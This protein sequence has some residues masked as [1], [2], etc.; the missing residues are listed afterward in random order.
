[1]L[2]SVAGYSYQISFQDSRCNSLQDFLTKSYQDS[3]GN[4]C[5]YSYQDVYKDFRRNSW[6][7]FCSNFYQDSCQDSRSIS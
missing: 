4:S 3:R 2:P 5:Q 6:K 7:D 1:M